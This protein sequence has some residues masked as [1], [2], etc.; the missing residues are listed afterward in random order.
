MVKPRASRTRK[1]VSAGSEASGYWAASHTL[2][3]LRFHLV[4][5][6]KYRRRVL[7]GPV[8]AR[9]TELLQQACE[10]KEW[11][12][13]ELSVQPDH[14][15]LLVQISPSD[16]VMNVMQILKGGTSRRLR[17]EFP[18]LEEFLWGDSFWGDG[19]FAESV[20]Q[21]EEAVLRAYIRN[22]GQKNE[23]QK[24]EGQKNQGQKNQGQKNQ[25][26]ARGGPRPS[27]K[28]SRP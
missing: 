9:L 6:P 27:S 25:G 18:E 23:G 13:H 10:V 19:Y 8:A 1:Q 24:N 26:Q 15:H 28:P 16:S 2:H 20:G 11:G 5:T 4:W 12:L 17:Q 14:V 3:R 7:E 21:K 22:Q